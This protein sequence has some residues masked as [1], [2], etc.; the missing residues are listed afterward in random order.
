MNQ[1]KSEATSKEGDE[2][3]TAENLLNFEVEFQNLSRGT[4]TAPPVSP[5]WTIVDPWKPSSQTPQPPPVGVVGLPVVGVGCSP[6]LY[7]G[8]TLVVS[9]YGFANTAVRQAPPGMT[10]FSGNRWPAPPQQQQQQQQG[11]GVDPFVASSTG[12]TLATPL[13]APSHQNSTVLGST[14]AASPALGNPFVVTTNPA[15]TASATNDPFAKLATGLLGATPASHQPGKRRADKSDFFPE[16]A[17][18]S[19][20]HLSQQQQQ[21]QQQERGDDVRQVE[22]QTDVD[23]FGATPFSAALTTTAPVNDPFARIE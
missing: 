2:S 15:S 9:P 3:T 4:G 13:T 14:D 22:Q 1:S 16:P 8:S 20:L 17:K 23:L 11:P 6:Q 10:P 19:L 21:Q 18:P 12:T 7:Q 5:I